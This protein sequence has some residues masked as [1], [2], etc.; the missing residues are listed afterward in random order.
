ERWSLTLE[1]HFDNLSLNYVAPV[2]R[3][4][5]APAV[6]KVVPVGDD[7][8][9]TELEALRWFAG[10]GSAELIDYDADLGAALIERLEPGLP[11]SSLQDDIAETAATAEVMRRVPR[12]LPE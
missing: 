12:P 6:L 10:A 9:V 7:E 11:V 8:S 3:A 2:R 1:P 5:G 4:D